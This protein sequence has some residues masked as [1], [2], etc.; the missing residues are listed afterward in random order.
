MRLKVLT[1]LAFIC[2]MFLSHEQLTAQCS[3]AGVCSVGKNISHAESGEKEHRVG[4]VYVLGRS[5]SADDITYHS[6]RVEGAIQISDYSQLSIVVPINAQTGPSGSASGIGDV[7]AVW[8]QTVLR[9]EELTLQV[10]LGGKLATGNANGNANLP[11]AYQSG[12]GTNDVL[13]GATVE[14]GGF[15]A[16]VA[17]QIPFGRSSN[18]LT[19]LKRGSD[20]LV[21]GGYSFVFDQLTVHPTLLFI[22]RLGESN[23]RNLGF[24]AGP[25]FVDVAESDQTQINLQIDGALRVSERYS[26]EAGIAFPFLKRNVNVDGLTRAFSL[27]AGAFVWF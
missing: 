7:I 15:D 11:Q 18:A 26:V 19:R 14:S 17:A 23:I 12:L 8:N 21:R 1:A 3:D 27:R 6:A 24:P 25:E 22:Q 2:Q 4:V 20:V 9:R 10:Q 5:T 13:F 16:S